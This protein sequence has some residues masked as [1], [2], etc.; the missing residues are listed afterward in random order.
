LR[1]FNIEYT[2]NDQLEKFLKENN[3]IDSEKILLQVFTGVCDEIFIN[4]LIDDIKSLLPS[5]NIIGS[6]TDGEILEG[7]VASLSTVLSFSIFDNTKIDIIRS[8]TNKSSFQA[9][10]SLI[11]EFKDIDNIKLAIVFADGLKTNGE[12]FLK[13]FNK[14]APDIIIA[15]GLAG[16]N[17]KFNQTFVFTQ[18]GL[19]KN[20]AIGAILSSE[21]L[22][23]NNSYSFGWESIGKELTVTKAVENIVY[24]IDGQSP[25]DIY[26]KYLG[27]DIGDQ[28]PATGIEFPLILKTKGGREVARAVVGKNDDFSLVFAGNISTGQKVHLAYGNIDNIFQDS[29]RCYNQLMDIPI[30]SI[31]VYSCMAR[32]RLL[33]DAIK[34][35]MLPMAKIA[36]VSGFFTYGEFF[37]FTNKEVENKNKLF[38]ETM[39]LLTLSEV[40]QIKKID[41][42]ENKIS[43]NTTTTIKALSNL[44]KE[45]TQELQDLNNSLETKVHNEVIKNL[46]KDQQLFEQSR[47]AQMGEMI[48][49]IAHQWRQPLSAISSIASGVQLSNEID[50]LTKEEISQNMEIIT[51]KTLYLSDTINTFRDFLKNDKNKEEVILQDKID[52]ALSIVYST[53]RDNNI[54]LINNISYDESIKLIIVT[55]ELPQVIINIINN[56]KDILVEKNIE[57]GWIKLDLIKKDDS[58]ILTIEDNA[59]GI[60]NEYLS[61]IFEPYFTTKHKSQGTGLGLHMSYKIMTKSLGGNLSAKN[62]E[63]GAVFYVELPLFDQID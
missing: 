33:G 25:I 60:P 59:G 5:I 46:E 13:A 54:E 18:Y 39:T 12:G 43:S 38:N 41:K 35:E 4:K 44:I 52:K 51:E 26:K 7:D 16:D 17:A 28:L 36:P 63:N 10:K 58:V 15:G 8:S 23:V 14:F 49:N 55:G 34:N 37:Y 29:N 30:E 50:L 31:F 19:C 56:A 2:S 57:N 21:H 47:L 11:K 42:I 9:A 61:K 32:K 1:T 27:D 40:D 62:S 22:I 6:T 24:E 53:V 3:I 45:T 20:M 48:G